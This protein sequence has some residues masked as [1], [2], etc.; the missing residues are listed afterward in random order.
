MADKTKSAALVI[1][2]RRPRAQT[3]FGTPPVA[4]QSTPDTS[5]SSTTLWY[6]QAETPLTHAT[7]PHA[8]GGVTLLCGAAP[9][10]AESCGSEWLLGKINEFLAES[11]E[12]E[13]T[14]AGPW[15]GDSQV[16]PLRM[17]MP[18]SPLRIEAGLTSALF[19]RGFSKSNAGHLDA[20]PFPYSPTVEVATVSTGVRV[21]ME[22]GSLRCI[23]RDDMLGLRKEE[24]ESRRYSRLSLGSVYVDRSDEAEDGGI[25]AS[26]VETPPVQMSPVSLSS[27]SLSSED[28]SVSSHLAAESCR[29]SLSPTITI[30]R[31]AT[32]TRTNR[33]CTA[34]KPTLF[35]P[36]ARGLSRSASVGFLSALGR[37]RKVSV[38]ASNTRPKLV[39]V[40]TTDALRHPSTDSDARAEEINIAQVKQALPTSTQIVAGRKMHKLKQ[41]LGAEVEE[42]LSSDSHSIDTT[43]PLPKLPRTRLQRSGTAV[44][45]PA[46]HRDGSV[47]GWSASRTCKATVT[48]RPSSA[49]DSRCTCPACKIG[50]SPHAKMTVL[51]GG[52]GST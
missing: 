35:A 22:Y 27:G 8:L 52:N 34:D 23:S 6:S 38:S 1:D 16:S 30:I 32:V 40:A 41:L 5:R 33:A 15:L 21:S 42:A 45:L 7:S 3:R 39:R 4:A 46:L 29:P 36:A 26:T 12:A 43:K 17:R 11:P 9:E 2:T 10:S 28:S 13:E 48:G 44:T 50:G 18:R 14:I 49:R 19:Y 51:L 31:D 47:R 24:N 25:T 37:A 20:A